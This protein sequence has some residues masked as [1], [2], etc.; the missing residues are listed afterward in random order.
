MFALFYTNTDQ[1]KSAKPKQINAA[2]INTTP[3]GEH[4]K[5]SAYITI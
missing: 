4:N 2:P 5:P 1:L 3:I